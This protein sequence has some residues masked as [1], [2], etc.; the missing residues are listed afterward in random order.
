MNLYIRTKN[1]KHMRISKIYTALKELYEEIQTKLNIMQE[2]L[3]TINK[4]LLTNFTEE[5]KESIV[6]N[7]LKSAFDNYKSRGRETNC[8]SEYAITNLD[9]NNIDTYYN[10]IKNNQTLLDQI[11]TGE[12]LMEPYIRAKEQNYE[13]ATGDYTNLVVCQIKALERYLKEVLIQYHRDNIWKTRPIGGTDTFGWKR[14]EEVSPVQFN[15]INH[16]PTAEDL[17]SLECGSAA[18]AL[19]MA[20]IKEHKRNEFTISPKFMSKG[21][22]EVRNGHLHIDTITTISDALMRRTQIAFWLLHLINELGDK[23]YLNR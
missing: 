6:K 8:T 17:N 15:R 4:Y 18:Y 14:I 5:K 9:I 10:S 21:I 19:L 2:N 7:F 20:Y 3:F 11:I 23:G 1:F 12:T 22:Q 13:Y 16:T